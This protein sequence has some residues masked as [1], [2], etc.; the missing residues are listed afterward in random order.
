M[1]KNHPMVFL[2]SN[3]FYEYYNIN[4]D[5]IECPLSRFTLSSLNY[6]FYF[7]FFDNFNSPSKGGCIYIENSNSVKE[8]I[9]NCIFNL[10]SSPGNSNYYGGGALYF[11]CSSGESIIDKTCA[12]FCKTTSPHKSGQFAFILTSYLGKNEF[13]LS[14]ITKC[15]YNHDINYNSPIRSEYGNEKY[16]L[17]NSSNNYCS[18]LGGISSHLGVLMNISFNSIM[19]NNISN[20]ACIYL[21][22]NDANIQYSNIINNRSPINSI[23]Y[24]IG[25]GI[26]QNCIFFDNKDTLFF[27]TNGQLIVENCFIEHNHLFYGSSI[28]YS[29][30]NN[31]FT[32]T[33]IYN[34]LHLF[35]FLCKNNGNFISNSYNQK[36]RFFLHFLNIIII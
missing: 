4:R 9:S 30:Y 14:T 10:C 36:L 29:N 31:Y 21:N 35:T 1:K 27:T 6:F 25:N 33:N 12:S 18:D 34:L 13:I 24:M 3:S 26:V 11:L 5:P 28:I 23:F 2:N 15:S 8:L 17:F 20:W 19:N 22:Y 7:C 16:L 32:K